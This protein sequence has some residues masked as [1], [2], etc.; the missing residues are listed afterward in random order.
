MLSAAHKAIVTATVP[1]LEA[2][3]EAL[4]TRFYQMLLDGHPEVRPMF[5]QAN[6]VSGE[7]PRALANGVLMYAKHIDRLEALGDLASQIV[8]KHVALQILPEH[9][10]VVG[11]CLLRAI[12]EV[13]GASTQ[14][15]LP[16][17]CPT[18]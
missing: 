16:N 15:R 8:Q 1:L 12:R 3:G 9:Y 6:Q 11:G 7:Q 13:L 4:T 17:G 18:Q 14:R 10:P 2:G 5:N